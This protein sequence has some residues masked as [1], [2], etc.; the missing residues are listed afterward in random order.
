MLAVSNTL[1]SRV[2]PTGERQAMIS[3]KNSKGL[4]VGQA[5]SIYAY[6]NYPAPTPISVFSGY[7]IGIKR[8]GVESSLRIRSRVMRIGTEMRF[9][10]FSPTIKE[11]RVIKE[12]PPKKIRRAKLFYMRDEKHDRGSVDAILKADRERREVSEKSAKA[13]KK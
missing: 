6:N 13:S 1:L 9:P 5:L 4:R 8:S 7:L 10:V 3:R 2:D 12:T 11:I